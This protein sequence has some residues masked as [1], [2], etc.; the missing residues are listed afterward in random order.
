MASIT[1]YTRY[2]PARIGFCIRQNDLGA[3][4]LATDF[5]HTI[6]GGR[7]CPI[8]PCDNAKYA[9]RIIRAFGVDT[10]YP[11]TKDDVINKLISDHKTIAW[12][13]VDPDLYVSGHN[14]KT[15]QFLA[16]RIRFEYF[17]IV[18]NS[19]LSTRQ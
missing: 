8:V 4:I 13:S 5:A 17:E 2:R 7:F 19:L 12:P 16:S 6:W 18:E 15:P 14:E 10:L 3:A 1:L 9:S 11:V